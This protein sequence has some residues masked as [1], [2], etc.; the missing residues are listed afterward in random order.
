MAIAPSEGGL[1]E[2]LKGYSLG[3]RMLILYIFVTLLGCMYAR[4]VASSK[5]TVP[6]Q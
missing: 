5:P 2:Q 6:T 3:N 1:T 4:T